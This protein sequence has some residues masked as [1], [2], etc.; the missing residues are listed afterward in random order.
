MKALNYLLILALAITFVEWGLATRNMETAMKK[1]R[2]ESTAR[3]Y[4][5]GCAI[6]IRTAER[7]GPDDPIREIWVEWCSQS[8][9]TFAEEMESK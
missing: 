5:I 4:A 7:L 9:K 3:G 2:V 1:E 6:A 8:A